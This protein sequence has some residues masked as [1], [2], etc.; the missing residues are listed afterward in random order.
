M[1][2]KLLEKEVAA[3]ANKSYRGHTQRN[4]SY[5]KLMGRLEERRGEH[6][7]AVERNKRLNRQIQI[8]EIKHERTNPYQQLVIPAV[9]KFVNSSGIVR[10]Y[11]EQIENQQV[12]IATLENAVKN[13]QESKGSEMKNLREEVLKL[14]NNARLMK[15]EN[16]SLRETGMASASTMQSYAKNL[17]TMKLENQLLAKEKKNLNDKLKILEQKNE[18]LRRINLHLGKTCEEFQ[19][20]IAKVKRRH[21][22]LGVNSVSNSSEIREGS[23]AHWELKAGSVYDKELKEFHSVREKCRKDLL[24]A[25]NELKRIEGDVSEKKAKFAEEFVPD[26]EQLKKARVKEIKEYEY[27]KHKLEEEIN[28]LVDIVKT[29]KGE[30]VER[31][32]NPVSYTHLT[33]PTICS[34]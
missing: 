1:E 4:N 8:L 11:K 28:S 25:E 34:V 3:L 33:L 5:T 14:K 31:K 2:I 13:L 23:R 15:A 10:S 22:K 26:Y 19:T 17:N 20:E 32:S 7:K 29:L 9:N 16:E 6:K 12:K 30:V 24:T 18:S 21:L 27:Q